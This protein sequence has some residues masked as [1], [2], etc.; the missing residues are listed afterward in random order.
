MD[1]WHDRVDAIAEAWLGGQGV[2]TAVADALFGRTN[3]SGKTSESFPIAVEDT[4]GFPNRVGERGTVL[5]G[6][7]V[8]I[9]YRWYDALRRSVRYPFGH[10]LSYT[11][12]SYSDLTV[13]VVDAE[14][15]SVIVAATVQNSGDRAGAEVV[16][17]YV[18]DPDAE[19]HRPVR[20]LRGFEKVRLE[21]GEAARVSFAL[22]NRDFAYWD[23]AAVRTDG[24]TGL[25]RREGGEFRVEVGASSRDIRLS[26][27][28]E[29]PD[30]PEI[31]PLVP[32]AEL[33][34]VVASR[35]VQG[36]AG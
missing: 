31:P 30:D 1:P 5:Y 26:A 23:A 36:H 6:E 7:G 2:G 24:R 18:G 11:S 13:D 25:W 14:A 16:Q 17:L 22:E 35:F 20:E 34:D 28:I 15:G 27:S 4:P 19:V 10:G 12:F 32:D 8:F 9:G 29:L 33:I 21:P 3:P